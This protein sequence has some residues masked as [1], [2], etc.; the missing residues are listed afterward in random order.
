MR[1]LD[2]P[3]DRLQA[4][5]RE[6]WLPALVSAAGDCGQRLHDLRCWHEALLGGD[7]P[8]TA[9]DFGDPPALHA[10]RAVVGELGLPALCRASPP[11]V[12]A[13]AAHTAV[14]PGPHCRSSAAPG[15]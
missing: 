7:L 4:L 1:D 15:A 6:L 13:S 11:L 3:Y 5:P 14:A 2:A 9:W 12:H 10:L 8:D